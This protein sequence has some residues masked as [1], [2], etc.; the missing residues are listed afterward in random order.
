[1][2]GVI[3]AVPAAILLWLLF[4]VAIA[5]AD[6]PGDYAKWKDN[7]IT[8]GRQFCAQLSSPTC[9]ADCRLNHIYYD[10]EKVFRKIQSTW[11][12][13]EWT[14][15]ALRAH[16]VYLNYIG[17]NALQ[18]QGFRNFT[19]GLALGGDYS[20]V[21]ELSTKAA[22]ARQESYGEDINNPDLS[23]E[24]SYALISYI[25][26]REGGYQLN[27]LFSSR[28]NASFSHLS[29][30]F[31][32]ADAPYVRPFM[33]ALTARS[34]IKA[35][36]QYPDPRTLPELSKAALW[37][38]SNTWLPTSRAFKYTDRVVP[39]GGVEPAPDLNLL[40]APLY[41]WLYFKTGEVSW[42]DKGDA[43]FE[44]GVN[45]AYCSSGKQYNQNYL[46]MHE[47]L[48]WRNSVTPTPTPVPTATPTRTPTPCSTAL[49]LK[50]H[51]C[52][53][54]LLEKKL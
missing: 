40:I 19:E 35:D 18:V 23:R 39:S 17:G 41:Y 16:E 42:R 27:S 3:Y 43:I 8:Y 15:C 31:G 5:K 22:Y 21:Y 29:H 1:M 20:T 12:G 49:S 38:W 6:F 34:L 54:K 9:D 14:A 13:T 28:R 25:S 26:A 46:W 47:G 48:L 32:V 52:R 4:A 24:I 50:G 33:V 2:R 53:L 7:A 44:G 51:E 36:E 37:L 30:W 45:Q 10:G 11:G